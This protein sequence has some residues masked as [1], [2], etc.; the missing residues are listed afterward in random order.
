MHIRTFSKLFEV[1]GPGF[2]SPLLP[3]ILTQLESSWAQASVFFS[4]LGD[5]NTEQG[6]RIS[7]LDWR[8]TTVA[9]WI[10]LTKVMTYPWNAMVGL[11]IGKEGSKRE[12][13]KGSDLKRERGREAARKRR[14]ERETRSR[15]SKEKERWSSTPKSYLLMTSWYSGYVLTVLFHLNE[16]LRRDGY[17]WKESH[18]SGESMSFPQYILKMSFRKPK[19]NSC[20]D[21]FCGH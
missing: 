7:D 18:W 16:A 21:L 11:L 19:S 20:T 15:E 6:I 3:E 5:C 2:S 13:G 4:P 10:H 14:R 17:P 8:F 9:L 12:V 1:S